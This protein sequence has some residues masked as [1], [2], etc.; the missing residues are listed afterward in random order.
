M[1]CSEIERRTIHVEEDSPITSTFKCK[2]LWEI[3]KTK[4]IQLI[5]DVPH[6]IAKVKDSLTAGTFEP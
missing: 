1:E 4:F 3:F 5:K 2:Q 6:K